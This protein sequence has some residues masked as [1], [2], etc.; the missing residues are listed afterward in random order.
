[1]KSLPQPVTPAKAGVQLWF[2]ESVSLARETIVTSS[3]Y[4]S[5]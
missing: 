3:V 4:Y 1:M 5:L 2:D